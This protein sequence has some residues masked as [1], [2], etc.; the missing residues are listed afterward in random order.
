MDQ[1]CVTFTVQILLISFT[2]AE[3]TT[4][5]TCSCGAKTAA[6]IIG[7]Y[8]PSAPV[9]LRLA[10]SLNVLLL[11]HNILMNGSLSKYAFACGLSQ[12]VLLKGKIH[13]PDIK[14]LWEYSYFNW[15]ESVNSAHEIIKQTLQSQT[16]HNFNSTD[17]SNL[18]PSCFWRGKDESNDAYSGQKSACIVSID[19]NFQHKWFNWVNSE[20]PRTS[21]TAMFVEYQQGT[22][23]AIVS[24]DAAGCGHSFAASDSAPKP[25]TMQRSDETGLMGVNCQHG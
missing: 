24:A 6:V 9:K 1:A 21:T 12:T 10:F 18:C 2:S 25:K 8:F 19:S 7:G 13:I 17:F 15:L 5:T 11:F 22:T 14:K 20:G 3:W 4:I 23:S 16:G